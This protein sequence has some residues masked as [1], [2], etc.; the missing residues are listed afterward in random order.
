MRSFLSNLCSLTIAITSFSSTFVLKEDVI[1][2]K[3]VLNSNYENNSFQ[4]ENYKGVHERNRS[5]LDFEQI[6]KNL[7]IKNFIIISTYLKES[8]INE[9]KIVLFI[10]KLLK[11][12]YFD[13]FYSWLFLKLNDCE[14]STLLSIILSSNI[15]IFNTWYTKSLKFCINSDDIVLSN[16][17]K[18]I[19]DLYSERFDKIICSQE[20]FQ[21]MK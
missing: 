4:Q 20:F 14:K 17:A 21:Q 1:N 11:K 16:K 6:Y 7:Y 9:D 12:D 3:Y 5:F 19:Y 2:N 10:K 18:D 8:D 13:N 15:D